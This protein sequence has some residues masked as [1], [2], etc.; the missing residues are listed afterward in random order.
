MSLLFLLCSMMTMMLN[1]AQNVLRVLGC[2]VMLPV[3]CCVV[4][5]MLLNMGVYVCCN[6]RLKCWCVFCMLFDVHCFN[7][8]WWF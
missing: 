8:F 5:S 4:F 2:L 6:V 1:A 3:F 7:V